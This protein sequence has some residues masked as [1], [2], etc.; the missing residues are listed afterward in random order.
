LYKDCPHRGDKINTMHNIQEDTTIEDMGRC[1]SRIY[2]SLEYQQEDY[3]SNMIEMEC[4]IINYPV[5][6]LIY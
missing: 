1:I 5:V 4:K 2:A 6:I 3:Q